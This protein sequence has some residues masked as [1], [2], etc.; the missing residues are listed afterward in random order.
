MA[1]LTTLMAAMAKA[2]PESAAARKVVDESPTVDV[3]PESCID[4]LNYASVDIDSP[5]LADYGDYNDGLEEGFEGEE[6]EDASG[7]GEDE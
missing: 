1:S 2:L 4:M 7:E 5:P 3:A 6:E